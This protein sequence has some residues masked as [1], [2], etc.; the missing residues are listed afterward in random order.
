MEYCPYLSPYLGL[1][2]A[3]FWRR[4]IAAVI[5]A[6]LIVFA[7]FVLGLL[8]SPFLLAAPAS[9]ERYFASEYLSVILMVVYLTMGW[10]YFAGFESSE[11]QATIGKTAVGILVTDVRG[12][13]IG[14][15][16]ATLRYLAKL[17]SLLLLGA[18]FLVMLRHPRRQTLHDRA[19]K[20]VVIVH[21]QS[22]L[23]GPG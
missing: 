13:R 4:A 2:Y 21:L 6:V 19:A 17:V 10:L 8:L 18:G 12:E 3:G 23:I 5:D 15:G 22:P 7:S 11:S 20:T 14:F 9:L 1:I 16:R